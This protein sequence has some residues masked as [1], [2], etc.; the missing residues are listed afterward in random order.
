[1][2]LR[3]LWHGTGADKE[4]VRRFTTWFEQEATTRWWWLALDAP[5]PV[6]M[7][8]LKLFERMPAPD[9]PRA[10]WGYLCNLFVAPEHRGHGVG[11]ALVAD[12]MAAA[13]EAGLVRVVLNP[14]EKSRP[15]YHR[16]GFTSDHGLLTR[17]LDRCLDVASGLTPSGAVDG[18]R[19][20][21]SRDSR[22]R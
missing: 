20:P 19:R 18:G 15:L 10:R 2:A 8:N 13:R 12:V 16:H 4:F 3:S 1:M 22:P 21:V 9:V 5:T 14:S 11:G 17:H 7:V 6:G